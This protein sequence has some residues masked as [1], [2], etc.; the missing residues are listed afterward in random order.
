M[1]GIFNL[2]LSQSSYRNLMVKNIIKI[3]NKQ[4]KVI[5]D[6]IILK[7]IFSLSFSEISSA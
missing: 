2:I 4:T 7:I 3:S 1:K 5:V 6:K